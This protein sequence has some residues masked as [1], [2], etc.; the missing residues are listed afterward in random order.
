M[1]NDFHFD[2]S[3]PVAL[4]FGL[5][6]VF[7]L[8]LTPTGRQIFFELRKLSLP[9][10]VTQPSRPRRP[11]V[12]VATANRD[13]QRTVAATVVPRGYNVLFA[14]TATIAGQ[15]LQ[16]D[17]ER[18]GLIVIN[19]EARDAWRIANLARSRV[20]EAT[21]IRLPPRHCSTEVATLLLTAI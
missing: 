20:P 12:L 19:A 17:A 7:I 15:L 9:E 5:I 8:C 21:L 10:T 14:D 6:V 1:E 3:W 11:D 16:S 4:V 18:I 2:L 13:D